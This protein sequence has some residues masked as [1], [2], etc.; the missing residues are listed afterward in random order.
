MLVLTLNICT[1]CIPTLNMKVAQ[2]SSCHSGYGVSLKLSKI[3]LKQGEHKFQIEE[4]ALI[5][6]Q[7]NFY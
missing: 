5:N 3:N 2:T 1:V 4:A 7:F 6:K